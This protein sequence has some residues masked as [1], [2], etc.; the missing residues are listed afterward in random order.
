ME[1][2]RRIEVPTAWG[3]RMGSNIPA[4]AWVGQPGKR[5]K[6][7]RPQSQA[8]GICVSAVATVPADGSGYTLAL[9]VRWSQGSKATEPERESEPKSEWKPWA[10]K[11][12]SPRRREATQ[13]EAEE[14]GAQVGSLFE[15]R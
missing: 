5:H 9:A 10:A 2:L 6:R 11:P 14:S 7:G 12:A 1:R 8:P 3:D 15:P 4:Q 13:T